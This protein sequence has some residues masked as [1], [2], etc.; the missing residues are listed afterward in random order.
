[1]MMIKRVDSSIDMGGLMV[2]TSRNEL[3]PGTRKGH[4]TE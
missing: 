4:S 3:V 2:K 1:M